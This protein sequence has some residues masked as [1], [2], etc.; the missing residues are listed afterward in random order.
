MQIIIGN[1]ETIGN[2]DEVDDAV[3][4]EFQEKVIELHGSFEG[5]FV[6][7]LTNALR[8][9]LEKYSKKYVILIVGKATVSANP[10][11]KTLLER[12]MWGLSER[13]RGEWE[14]IDIGDKVLIYSSGGIRA[15]GEIIK[16]EYR[17]EPVAEWDE[18]YRYP[19]HIWVKLKG[20]TSNRRL[21]GIKIPLNELERKIS[22]VPRGS[23]RILEST[24]EINAIE[25][26][27]KM[28][29]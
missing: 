24:D 23:I 7:E 16:K 13:Y 15:K 27:L 12:G 4:R 8:M 20:I 17:P 3:W 26:L 9:W 6:K 21:P 11:L 19:Y 18:P 14:R 2:V 1:I 10:N 29:D 25:E 28:F 22:F 5:Y